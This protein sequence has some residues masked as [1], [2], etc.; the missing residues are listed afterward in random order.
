MGMIRRPKPKL[1]YVPWDADALVDALFETDDLYQARVL[2]KAL[3]VKMLDDT[4][5]GQ[6]PV[7]YLK[8][9]KVEERAQEKTLTDALMQQW[10]RPLLE[11]MGGE[12]SYSL[13]AKCL[14]S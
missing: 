1:M 4:K 12:E 10:M 7:K 5:A 14:E 11:S 8:E 13:R 6:P 2:A 9:N 3:A